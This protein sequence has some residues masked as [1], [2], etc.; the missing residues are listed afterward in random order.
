MPKVPAGLSNGQSIKRSHCAFSLLH[1]RVC[2]RTNILLVIST[3][4]LGR[5]FSKL[6]HSAFASPALGFQP[7]APTHFSCHFSTFPA[8]AEVQTIRRIWWSLHHIAESCRNDDG[9][10][11]L[12]STHSQLQSLRFVVTAS[13]PLQP[14]VILF[15]LFIQILT[16]S[17]RSAIQMVVKEIS[18]VLGPVQ[19]GL[20][21]TC[22][23]KHWRLKK[24]WHSMF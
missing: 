16:L 14:Y 15:I 9:V 13:I 21:H 12:F 22:F 8:V 20:I 7:Q 4:V 6:T 3:D 5:E 19:P 10:A 11:S 17:S 23:F 24:I 18:N 2:F 1:H